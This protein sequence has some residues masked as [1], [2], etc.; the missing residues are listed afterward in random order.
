M[1]ASIIRASALRVGQ[2]VVFDNPRYNRYITAIESTK[3]GDLLIRYNYGNGGA[4]ATAFYNP[5]EFIR[6]S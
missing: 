5:N 6:A 2:W 3:G 1:K 4:S